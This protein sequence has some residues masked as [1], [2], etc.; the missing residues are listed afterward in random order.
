MRQECKSSLIVAAID[1]QTRCRIEYLLVI[2]LNVGRLEC[3]V[4][5]LRVGMEKELRDVTLEAHTHERVSVG[6]CQQANDLSVKV[7]EN[8][9]SEKN[10][11]PPHASP[12][13]SKTYSTLLGLR[14]PAYHSPHLHRPPGLLLPPSSSVFSNLGEI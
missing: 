7:Y 6:K 10:A 8:H 2:V 1:P 12:P 4:Q 5:F 11:P 3:S 13:P 14:P 9:M